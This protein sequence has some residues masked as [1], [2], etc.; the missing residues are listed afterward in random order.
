MGILVFGSANIDETY[1]V[2]HMVA[3][4]ET[5][6]ATAV[7]RRSGGKGLNQ[8]IACARAGTP[9][10]FA[11]AIGEDGR[12]LLGELEAAGVDT[13]RVRV[14]KGER[15]GVAVIQNDAAGDNCILLY[16]GANRCI[17]A[18]QVAGALEG[19]GP[20]D[21]V[22]LQNEVN[23]TG[24]VIRAAHA[25]GISVALN[26]SPLDEAVLA[27]PLDLVG[28]LLLNEVEAAQLLGAQAAGAVAS[29]D[30]DEV[31]ALLGARF[32]RA[33]V[34]LTLG[35]AGSML[36]AEGEVSVRQPARSREVVD[37]TAAGDTFTGFLLAALARGEEPAAAMELAARA[38][39]LAVSRPGAAPSIPTLE[40]VEAWA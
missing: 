9:T 24:T 22:V 34:V 39:G 30:W 6:A 27:M 20:G 37:T 26:P 33:T 25:R 38:A 10:A 16:G 29:A 8:A 40:E 2:P 14:L 4:G 23:L 19:Y 12:F 35:G 21:M 5:L 17:A 15:T 3:R 1:S 31:A 11:G 32:P 28:Y 18:E 36:I 7:T 13:S